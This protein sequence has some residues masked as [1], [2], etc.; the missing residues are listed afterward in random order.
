MGVNLKRSVIWRCGHSINRTT[1]PFLLVDVVAHE[2][3]GGEGAMIT[4]FLN[5]E[6]F[7]I[8]I[9]ILDILEYLLFL[10]AA[11]NNV[12]KKLHQTLCGAFLPCSNHIRR[13]VL[14]HNINFKVCPYNFIKKPSLSR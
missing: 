3:I 8:F 13:K 10:I 9:V 2:D 1:V 6:E 11:G 4:V 7:M 14:C 5:G 12:V